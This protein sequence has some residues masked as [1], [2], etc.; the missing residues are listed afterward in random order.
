MSYKEEFRTVD[1]IIGP[2]AETRAVDAF[3][4]SLVKAERQIRKLVT[5]LVYQFPCFGKSDVSR[6]RDTLAKNNKVYFEGCERGFDALYPRSV[7]ELIGKDYERLRSRLEEA[8]KHRNKIFH[9]Q[10]TGVGLKRKDLLYFVDDIR[11]WC[12]ILAHGCLSE[13]QYDGFGRN[14]FRKSD[15]SQLWK[16]FKISLRDVKDYEDFIRN[17][18]E[19]TARGN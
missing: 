7:K 4:L 13:F 18:M 16:R 11:K 6:L 3:A 8:N 5:H 10:I 19:R 12:E 1:L 15:V 14:S 9:G 2:P 17:K